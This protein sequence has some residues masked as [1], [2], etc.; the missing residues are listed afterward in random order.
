MESKNLKEACDAYIAHLRESGVAKN[1]INS[2][3]WNLRLLVSFMGE[4]KE[5]TKIMPVHISNFYRSELVTSKSDADGNKVERT[6]GSISQIKRVV[7]WALSWFFDQGWIEKIPLPAEE[8]RI[9]EESAASPGKR[10]RKTGTSKIRDI[11]EMKAAGEE[12]SDTCEENENEDTL[13]VI[14]PEDSNS[15]TSYGEQG[16][17]DPI[18]EPDNDTGSG[19]NLL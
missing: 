5:L 1:S 16:S 19:F 13:A 12:G 14:E 15:P 11:N 9:L 17:T 10:S 18:G 7:R 2:Y 6:T 8:K 3:A 4:D